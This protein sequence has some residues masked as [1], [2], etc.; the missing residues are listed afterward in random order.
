MSQIWLNSRTFIWTETAREFYH[1]TSEK[2]LENSTDW[3]KRKL[4]FFSLSLF[5]SPETKNA[6]MSSALS[7]CLLCFLFLFLFLIEIELSICFSF[8]FFVLFRCFGNGGEIGGC[9][10]WPPSIP[11]HKVLPVRTSG[12]DTGLRRER[13][14]GCPVGP[15]RSTAGIP[16][17]SEFAEK[18]KRRWERG[19]RLCVFEKNQR[20][21]C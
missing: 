19:V 10:M 20:R 4:R 16:C 1:L 9:R 17:R 12:W 11:P 7:L 21:Y 18:T 3:V 2:T 6:E 5:L 15:V 8:A 13:V 14:R